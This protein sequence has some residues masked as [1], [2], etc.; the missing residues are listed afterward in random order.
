MPPPRSVKCRIKMVKWT[1]SMQSV[2]L[3][4]MFKGPK[5]EDIKFLMDKF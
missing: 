3:F 1:V 4:K 5:V 2:V